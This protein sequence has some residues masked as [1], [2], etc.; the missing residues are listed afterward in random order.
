MTVVQALSSLVG[1][2]GPYEGEAVDSTTFLN[3]STPRQRGLRRACLKFL[4]TAIAAAKDQD[5]KWAAD[6]P[7]ELLKTVVPGFSISYVK[8][9]SHVA[10]GSEAE[11]DETLTVRFGLTREDLK[12][13]SRID[14]ASLKG[15]LVS[16]RGMSEKKADE[17][18][19][20]CLEPYMVQGAPSVRWTPKLARTEEL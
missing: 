4:E 14:A 15:L 19:K 16:T 1:P 11:A 5:A 2:G 6:V 3:P 13:V 17:E 20:K 18:I 8:G 12:A 7:A 10:E 9:R